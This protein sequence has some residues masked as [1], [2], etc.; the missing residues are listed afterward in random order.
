MKTLSVS[1]LK[2]HLSEE[3]RYVQAGEEVV[4]TDRGRPVAR[5][6]P[7]TATTDALQRLA[8]AGLARIGPGVDERF[9]ELERATDDGARL[10]AA[11]ADERE[12]GW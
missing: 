4:V 8:S 7:F 12:G 11:V 10:R 5:L 3:L 2:A 1:H 6:V 9:W